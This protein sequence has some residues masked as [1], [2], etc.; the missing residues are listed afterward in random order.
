MK[1]ELKP[2]T[3]E[4]VGPRWHDVGETLLRAAAR[5]V[6]R[7]LMDIYVD[8]RILDELRATLAPDFDNLIMMRDLGTFQKSLHKGVLD[9]DLAHGDPMEWECWRVWKENGDIQAQQ[10]ELAPIEEE[11]K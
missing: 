1:Y 6:D 7:Y 2:I 8:L 3:K 4:I 10:V 11:G 9:W 5:R